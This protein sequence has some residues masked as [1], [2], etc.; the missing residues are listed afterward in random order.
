MLC[1]HYYLESVEKNM[2]YSDPLSSF[3]NSSKYLVLEHECA[4]MNLFS[5]SFYLSRNRR[6]VL[7]V[8][9]CSLEL[10]SSFSQCGNFLQGELRNNIISVVKQS[11]ALNRPGAENMKPRQLSDAIQQEIGCVLLIFWCNLVFQDFAFT[12]L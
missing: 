5:I 11:S 3:P 2:L 6:G 8:S 10:L 4:S 9:T 1:L 12:R 7:S